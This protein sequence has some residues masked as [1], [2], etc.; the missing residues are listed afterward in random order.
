MFIPL[1]NLSFNM[2]EIKFS[3][4]WCDGAESDLRSSLEGYTAARERWCCH[5]D[6]R[7]VTGPWGG[8]GNVYMY[9]FFCFFWILNH[10][11]FKWIK[12]MEKKWN[13]NKLKLN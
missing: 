2:A 7:R 13:N 6:G 12:I 1:K 9:I 8:R 10:Y 5:H 3:P 4:A 11:L